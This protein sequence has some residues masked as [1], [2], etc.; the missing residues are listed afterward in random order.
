MP[1]LTICNFKGGVLKTSCAINI[2]NALEEKGK[3]TLLVDMDSQCNSSTTF[4]ADL[5]KNSMEE[6]LNR[7]CSLKDAIQSTE[8]G[9]IVANSKGLKGMEGMFSQN[10]E[11]YLI[12]NDEIKK[13][14]GMYDYIIIDTPPSSGFYSTSAM[15]ASDYI[16]IPIKAEKYSI[17]GLSDIIRTIQSTQK[18]MNPNLKVLGVLL[19]AYDGRMKLDKQLRE[20][21]PEIIEG[22]GYKMFD[23][24]IRTDSEI[25]NAQAESR[26]LIKTRPNCNAA[27]DFRVFV[28]KELMT[29]A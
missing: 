17:D 18:T 22:L 26:N 7:K 25:K 27:K 5:D 2:A 23:T 12:L 15:V 10:L 21:M 6:V 19:T 13:I 16:I 20:Q 11:N 8:M 29:I 1:V 4:Q 3:K 9:D 28:E 14:E 24:V